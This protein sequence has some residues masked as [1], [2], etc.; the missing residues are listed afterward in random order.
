MDIYKDDQGVYYTLADGILYRL[1]IEPNSLEDVQY[2]DENPITEYR[3][4]GTIDLL[5]PHA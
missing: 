3:L 2:D 5:N 1:S 4:E